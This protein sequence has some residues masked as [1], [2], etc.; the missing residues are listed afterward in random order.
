LAELRHKLTDLAAAFEG[1]LQ[2]VLTELEVDG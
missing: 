1:N 2:E